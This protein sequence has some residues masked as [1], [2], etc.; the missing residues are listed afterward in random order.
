MSAHILVVDDEPDL[1]E[2]IRQRFRKQIRDKQLEFSFAADGMEA[3]SQLEQ[4]VF[5]D[6]VLTDINM[7]RMD[8]L[9]LISKIR[10]LHPLLKS[11]I[12]SAYGDMK[13]IRSALNNGAFDFVTKPIDFSDLEITI[14][15]TLEEA[16][17]T[18]LAYDN[19]NKL[20]DIEKELQ[21][22][23]QIQQSILP[24]HF[25]AF[26][27]RKDFD[28]FAKMIPAKAVGG[29]L[30]D[31]FLID[32]NKLGF[33]IG[34]VSGKGVPAALFMAVTKTLLKSVALQKHTPGECLKRVNKVLHA[35]SVSEVFVTMFYGILD[36]KTGQLAYS[37]GGHNPTYILKENGTLETVAP[38]GGIP[39]S[40]IPDFEYTTSELTLEKNDIIVTYTDG[41]N[42]AMDAEENEFSEERLEGNLKENKNS[43]P[44]K[45]ISHIFKQ[46]EIF[47]KGADQS[48]DITMLAVQFKG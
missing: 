35:E 41:V 33:C 42:E 20:V 34:D 16:R 32:R 9:S 6:M 28:V 26:P 29:D 23:M 12:I 38:N 8:G 5:F 27:E 45:V 18:R 13:N 19:Q 22:A 44:E 1:A 17:A 47:T 48:D 3:L 40:F 46:V 11:V 31:F 15:R 43:S 7:P 25:P 4:K 39:I 14:Q 2:L 30:Y 21:I 10:E 37:N 24:R 36:T